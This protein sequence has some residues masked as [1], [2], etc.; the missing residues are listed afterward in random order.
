MESLRLAVPS[1]VVEHRGGDLIVSSGHALPPVTRCIGDWLV[2]WAARTPERIFVAERKLDGNWRRETY[3]SSLRAAESLGSSLLELGATATRPVMV[4]ADN[5]V[6]HALLQLGAMHAG[7]PVAPISTAYAL[8]SA[9]FGRL[10]EVARTLAPGVIVV[11]DIQRYGRALDALAQEG[12]GTIP[13]ITID[14]QAGRGST[15]V[16]ALSSLSLIHI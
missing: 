15:P 2:Q 6:D 3:S 12:L 14:G 7:V 4:L 13:V 8:A 10:R 1:A 5:G 16:A 11:D 9:D